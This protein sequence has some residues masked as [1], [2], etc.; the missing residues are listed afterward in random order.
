MKWLSRLTQANK[1]ITAFYFVIVAWVVLGLKLAQTQEDAEW[2]VRSGHL[3]V[4]S[5][6]ILTWL[7]FVYESEHSRD[8]AVAAAATRAVMESREEDDLTA[9]ATARLVETEIKRRFELTRRRFLLTGLGS[10]AFGELLTA[11]GPLL[12]ETWRHRH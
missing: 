2:I 8:G 12:F 11:F 4:A 1:A 6:L 10:A 9:D 7:Q 3:V 5:S